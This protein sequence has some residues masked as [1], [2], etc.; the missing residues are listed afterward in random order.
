MSSLIICSRII[1][2][3]IRDGIQCISIIKYTKYIRYLYQITGMHTR[4]PGC[5]SL[6]VES[7]GMVLRVFIYLHDDSTPSEPYPDASARMFGSRPRKL[8]NRSVRCLLQLILF[9]PSPHTVETI[10]CVTDFALS[11]GDHRSRDLAPQTSPTL[12]SWIAEGIFL[13][14]FSRLTL[15]STYRVLVYL[16]LFGSLLTICVCLLF[17]PLNPPFAEHASQAA[18]AYVARLKASRV[19]GP[20]P[21]W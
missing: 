8:P 5:I 16:P 2:V 13:L 9:S 20:A 21:N 15:P 19:A 4:L 18:L 12:R 6:Y 1:I 7:L 17:S 3:A 11:C 14:I 10:N